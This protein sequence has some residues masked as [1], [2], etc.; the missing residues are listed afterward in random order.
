MPVGRQV[1]HPVNAHQQQ[2]A[3]RMLQMP[4]ALASTGDLPGQTDHYYYLERASS[5]SL[6]WGGCVDLRLLLH[7]RSI[8]CFQYTIILL[9][10]SSSAFT[11][12]SLVR[13][14]CQVVWRAENIC[15]CRTIICTN[16]VQSNFYQWQLYPYYNLVR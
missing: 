4:T 3:Q 15:M 14:S 8:P 16:P 11:S 6:K 5:V 7:A 1:I 9:T 13:L 10:T 2:S 12:L